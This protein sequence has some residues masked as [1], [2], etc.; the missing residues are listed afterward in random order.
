[1]NPK[2]KFLWFAAIA[3]S[4]VILVIA[5]LSALF[6]QPLPPDQKAF[7]TNFLKN[8]FGYFFT[9]AFFILVILGLFLDWFFRFYIIP[10]GQ[11]SDEAEL[12]CT[13]NPAHRVNIDGSY[14]VIRLCKIINQNAEHYEKLKNSIHE[15][16]ERAKAEL[17]AEKSI[18]ASIM[19]ELPEG[20]LI[21]NASGKILLYN[22]QAQRFFR[23]DPD[24]K[25]KACFPSDSISKDD[26]RGNRF[27]GL[28]RSIY[29]LVDRH[30]ID[31]ALK[32]IHENIKQQKE[33]VAS[34]FVVV[35][36]ENRILKAE[37]VPV[38]NQERDFSGFTI[39]FRDITRQIKDGRKLSAHIESI[40]KKFRASISGIRS[41]VELILEF[42]QMNPDQLKSFID[43]IHKEAHSLS[44]L[45][46]SKW[47]DYMAYIKNQWPLVPV[48]AKNLIKA[49]SDK[50][51]EKINISLIPKAIDN[52]LNV[53]VDNYL[54]ILAV[55]FILE[56]LAKETGVSR[57]KCDFVST[58]IFIHLDILWDGPPISL[59]KLKLWEDMPLE[60]EDEKIP[61]TL[62]EVI[63]HHE[64]EM[65]SSSER[66]GD[67]PAYLRFILPGTSQI[68]TLQHVRPVTIITHGR[69][70]FY[71][72]DLFNQEGQTPELDN[73]LL[74]S[75]TYTVF[76][77]ETTGLDPI[78]G[79]E[80]ISIGAIRVFNGR[81]LKD[82]TF[83]QL[84][85][86]RRRIPE[87]SIEIHKIQP[88]MLKGKPVIKE[89][90]PVFHK[91]VGNTVLVAHNAAFD[92]R[93]LQVKEKETGIKFINP[94]LDTLLLSAVAHPSHK[95]HAFEAIAKRLG[96]NVIGRHTALGDAITTAQIFL[97]LIYILEQKGI[98]TLKEA[99]E[100]S[101]KTFYSRLKY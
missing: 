23:C 1:M 87:K 20:V 3:I 33:S 90:L 92:M 101:R 17:E 49:I 65:W 62:G 64:A 35:S 96:V 19:A 53:R 30:L 36:R 12:M 58:D 70:E 84:I 2:N 44:H 9:I 4:F 66:A 43:I 86:P 91:F 67:S 45:I 38:L 11:L 74:T 5:T 24:H 93:M 79:D 99:R 85:N 75:L 63:R 100:A 10:I 76:D 50:A 73:R 41:A 31:H 72:F 94:V 42:S 37:A 97:K 34:Y 51:E 88:E 98:K 61:L 39:I 16:I 56:K 57:F 13:V 26:D 95:N 8:N 54:F 71:D 81:I 21:C 52:D 68:G 27:I 40:A 80:I 7:L 46:D 60:M 48:N 78:G 25:D 28:G 82:E 29:D 83:E 15:E 89:V 6:W 69:P 14:D 18:F 22:K 59:Q 47:Y 55:V 77:T 32:E